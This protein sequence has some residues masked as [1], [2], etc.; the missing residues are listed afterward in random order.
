MTG[1]RNTLAANRWISLV[2]LRSCDEAYLELFRK[3][4]INQVTADHKLTA[5]LVEHGTNR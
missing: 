4:L 5:T 3:L 2:S 1:R